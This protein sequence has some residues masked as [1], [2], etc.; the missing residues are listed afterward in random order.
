MIGL[1]LVDVDL[2]L[3]FSS[4]CQTTLASCHYGPAGKG[5]DLVDTMFCERFTFLFLDV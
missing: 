4:L 1:H 3:Q 5:P 2:M